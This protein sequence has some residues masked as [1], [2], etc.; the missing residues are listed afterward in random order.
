MDTLCRC[1]EWSSFPGTLTYNNLPL[2]LWILSPVSTHRAHQLLSGSP[3][4]VSYS[5]NFF[6]AQS[7]V[8]PLVA[9]QDSLGLLSLRD[10]YTLLP[11]VKCLENYCLVQSIH[12]LV[13]S[14]SK[15]STYAPSWLKV[16][17]NS[18]DV[19]IIPLVPIFPQEPGKFS[20]RWKDK[21]NIPSSKILYIF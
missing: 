12:V 18:C 7:W 14:G 5:E 20:K 11:N 19:L 13:V 10:N 15:F 3:L 8:I 17:G 2:K 1:Q 6:K 21:G 9:Q 16:E 4:P